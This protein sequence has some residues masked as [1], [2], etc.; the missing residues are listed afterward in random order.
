VAGQVRAAQAQPFDR[1]KELEQT[2]RVLS[3]CRPDLLQLRYDDAKQAALRELAAR[4]PEAR[5]LGENQHTVKGNGGC[6]S[7]TPPRGS[8]KAATILARLK[9]DAATNPRARQAL[10]GIADGTIRSARQA[11]ILAGFIK[12]PTALDQLRPSHSR[13]SPP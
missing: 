4:V 5:G 12:V 11:G 3:E 10:D 13:C 6:A 9:R 7:G 8:N 2:Y 1:W